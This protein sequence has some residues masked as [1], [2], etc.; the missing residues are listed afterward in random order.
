MS[1]IERVIDGDTFI[2]QDERVRVSNIDTAE[3]KHRDE[4]RNTKEGDIAYKFAKDILPKG[5]PIIT[6]DYGRDHFGRK[7]SSATR[8]INGVDVDYGLVA[9]DQGMSTYFVEYGEHPDPLKHDAY[10]EYYSKYTPYQFGATEEPLTREQFDEMTAKQELFRKTYNTFKEGETTQEEFDRV[11]ADLYGNPEMVMRYRHQLSNW[12][13]PIEQENTSTIR[14]AIRIAVEED[15]ALKEQYNRAVRSSHLMVDPIPEEEPSKL[16]KLFATYSMQLSVSNLAD[17]ELLWASR[18]L[19]ED[20]E[21]PEE[22]LLRGVPENFHT[23]V[24]EE[25][26]KYND[27]AALV[28]RDQLIEDTENNRIFDNLEW[29]A[30]F[31]YGALA[32]ITDPLAIAAATPIGKGG[33]AIMTGVKAWTRN[34]AIRNTALMATWATGGAL[35]GAA[36]NTPRLSGDHTYTAKDLQL[37]VL[38]DASFGLGLGAAVEYAVKPTFKRFV[39]DTRESRKVEQEQIQQIV[40]NK[41]KPTE[42]ATPELA[43]VKEEANVAKA[44]SKA[45]ETV[46]QLTGTKFT[47]WEA[48]T[49]VSQEGF[50]AAKI[51]LQNVFPQN[52][53][54][55][56]LINSQIG[57][58]RKD[59][60]PEERRIANELN[61]DILHLVSAFP[62]GKVPKNIEKAIEAVTFKQRTFKRK[63]AV[64]DVLQGH[65]TNPTKALQDYVQM[66]RNH[67]E[68]WEGYDPIPVSIKD[69][70]TQQSDWIAREGRGT[71]DDIVNLTKT[72]PKEISYLKD[73]AEL[74]A[75]ARKKNDQ[76]FTALVEELNGLATTRI[77]QRELGDFRTYS[78]STKRFSKTVPMSPTEVAAQLKKEG[79]TP[80]TPA[81]SKRMKELRQ[82]GRVVVSKDVRDIGKIEEF[83]VGRDIS[84]P[85]LTGQDYYP[86]EDAKQELAKLQ[87]KPKPTEDD[88]ARS[89]ELI[90]TIEQAKQSKETTLIQDTLEQDLLPRSYTHIETQEAYKNPTV[91]TLRELKTRLN[92]DILRK[93]GVKTIKGKTEKAAQQQRLEQVKNALIKDKSK[94][95]DRMI[96]AG[97]WQNIEDVIRASNT[98]V[99]QQK[100]LHT[101]GE[102]PS[103]N[104]PLNEDE[105]DILTDKNSG[106]TTTKVPDDEYKTIQNKANKAY[107]KMVE[108]ST[109][110]VST[111]L[112]DFVRT[113]EKKAFEL[114]RK[115]RGIL[116]V[117]GT[118]AA[119]ITEDLGTKFQNGK[120]TSL[121]YIGS[122][123]TEI[124]KGYG[125]AIRRRETGGII[126]DAVHKESIMQIAPQYVKAIDDYAKSKGLG[127]VRRLYA[128]QLSGADSKLVQQF[129]KDVFL[130]QEYRRQDKELPNNL[131]ESVIKFVDDWDKYMD[132]NH[133]K[134]VEAKIGGFTKKRKV[135]HYIPHIWQSNKLLSVINKHGEHKVEEL[136]TRAYQSSSTNNINP[137]SPDKARELAKRQIQWIKDQG[138]N[139]TDQFIPV[140]DSR[141]KQ[142]LDLDTTMEFEGLS[143][144]DLLDNEVISV[145]NKYSNR[146]AGWVGL[147][148]S[149]DGMLTSQLDIDSLKKNLI[150]E[151]KDKNIGTKTYEQYY[152]D[153]IDLMF[154]R[155]TRGGL[156]QE[157]RQ[158]KDLTALT[159]MGGLGTAQAIETGQVI[160]RSVLNTFSSEPVVRKV[161]KMARVKEG[162]EAELIREIQSISNITDDFEWIDRQ[163]VHLDQAELEKIKRARQLSLWIADKATFGKHKA[164]ASRLLGKTTGYNAIRRFQSRITQAS[165]AVDVAKHF[166]DK[167]GKMG[168]ARMADVGLTDANGVD[169]ELQEVFDN[170]VEYGADGL[171]K[172]LN[173]DKWPESAR[174]KFQYALLRDEAQQIQRTHVGELPPWM[175]KPLMALAFQFRQMP[176]VATNK[177]MSRSL[178]FAD[179]EA[180]TATMLNA[181]MSGLVRYGK[182][183]G[184]G[185]GVTAI[186]G[187]EW[188]DPNEEQMQVD[189]YITQFGIFPDARDLVLDAYSAGTTGK[190]SD[191][192]R[193]LGQVPVMGLMKDYYDSGFGDK[194]EQI[195]AAQG[196]VPLG[197][198]AYGD[199]IHTWIQ[200]EFGD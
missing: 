192:E 114:A 87:K 173:V 118:K 180:V 29:Y 26:T 63:N 65:T 160:T 73:L 104:T 136:F 57:L 46:A 35:E 175:N 129:N 132:Y 200:E 181:A 144:L 41:D 22:E 172:K 190:T 92:Q 174:K 119:K 121:E 42:A 91:E 8:S 83:V 127:V 3:S 141:A 12:N 85:D 93:L 67:T 178:A 113:G 157:L 166:K 19:G 51:A 146:V 72:L 45:K 183:V 37:D 153:L 98:V 197:N 107:E 102:K 99:E 155:P 88:V 167:S 194:R 90:K 56:K 58:N 17:T 94:V 152:D 54:M 182:F 115:P 28:L 170:L 128:Q 116:D 186:T 108:D 191:I 130:I 143:I 103:L 169:L 50:E 84:D 31:G 21:I 78:D 23:A 39:T 187:R 71:T 163:S 74:N 111:R 49:E 125:G 137:T 2:T 122:R 33:Q 100:V 176:I 18:R 171:L 44:E 53:A 193:L 1:N 36:V 168:N 185:I 32:T 198:T 6:H 69:F 66:L 7:V 126:R 164:P 40:E 145:A 158:L 195:D 133:G 10:K 179:K 48:I 120:I 79:L 5:E 52:T 165:F 34:R 189:K 60:K 86:I 20:A 62:D 4:A 134:L 96:K 159:R 101:D 13:R 188:Q 149:T 154:G 75:M 38:M 15:P 25:A 59:L 43:E 68:L 199:M 177:Q 9:L 76:A 140:A 95:I 135:K 150:Q 196:L 30:Q 16:K 106:E 124:G 131:H 139:P 151:G 77:E 105:L 70:F 123:I 55:R 147:S 14:S 27:Q 24:L 161:M 110:G 138:E 61:S 81:Y 148:E 47:P 162:E 117:A 156:N 80:R 142:R 64:S 97:E 112:A 82:R 184:L 89:R 109:E 11:T